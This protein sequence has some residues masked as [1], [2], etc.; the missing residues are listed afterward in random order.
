MS[1]LNGLA[2]GDDDPKKYYERMSLE[3]QQVEGR[4]TSTT[5]EFELTVSNYTNFTREHQLQMQAPLTSEEE[6]RYEA[7]IQQLKVKTRE[8]ESRAM[9]AASCE[10][11]RSTLI[12]S[13]QQLESE[14]S[15][16]GVHNEDELKQRCER[17]RLQQKREELELQLQQHLK[18]Q[19]SAPQNPQ[20]FTMAQLRDAH[21]R[22]V[23]HIQNG[24]KASKLG[25]PYQQKDLEEALKKVEGQIEGQ[26]ILLEYENYTRLQQQIERLKQ[27]LVPGITS[28]T[29][30]EVRRSLHQHEISSNLLQCPKCETYLRYN[31]SM[32]VDGAPPPS[33][34]R[35]HLVR[36]LMDM[37]RQIE[38]Q[39]Q[40]LTME[41][42]LAHL[43]LPKIPEGL[44]KCPLNQLTAKRDA[45]LGIT[46]V[47][48]PERSASEIESCISW[49]QHQ[50][51][52]Q[53]LQHQLELLPSGEKVDPSQLEKDQRSFHHRNSL[54]QQKERLTSQLQRRPP[55]STSSSALM[56]NKRE[57]E[58]QLQ[59]ISQRVSGG[60][61]GRTALSLYQQLEQSRSSLEQLQLR[62]QGLRTMLDLAHR[63]E[64]Q[65]LEG[66]VEQINTFIQQW[67][68]VLFEGKI[69]LSLSLYRP[70]KSR[71]GEKQQLTLNI[72]HNEGTTAEFSSCSGGEKERINLLL[73]LALNQQRGGGILILDETLACL[74][75]KNRDVCLS[76]LRSITPHT[77]VLVVNH[78]ICEGSFDNLITIGEETP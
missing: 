37:E 72:H 28:S 7:E 6:A 60:K 48:A 45:L 20:R 34:P 10:T 59:N 54:L 51:H 49:F 50:D 39:R 9:E 75:M 19:P 3:L 58:L 65:T 38:L 5:R 13:L 57:M 76:L 64:C 67:C 73:T 8:L 23:L 78:E 1:L 70:L 4:M 21:H 29:V 66:V 33:F 31:G 35:E 53:E 18:K 52:L 16:L 12:R 14:L 24:E 68:P 74:D 22:E 15:L 69:S 63:L 2:F 40:I 56:A 17:L 32:L 55:P 25:I 47:L 43:P 71:P 44:V 30:E 42:E 27:Q 61:L 46:V 11:E 41:N 77:T 62:S 36:E 26:K